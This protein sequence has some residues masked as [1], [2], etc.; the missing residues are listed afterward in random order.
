M[1]LIGCLNPTEVTHFGEKMLVPCGKCLFCQSQRAQSLVQ[2]MQLESS[3]HKYCIFGTLTYANMFLP[4]MH[5]DYD[6]RGFYFSDDDNLSVCSDGGQFFSFPYLHEESERFIKK[7]QKFYGFIP[8]LSKYDM[9]CFFKRLRIN[10]DRLIASN[11]PDDDKEKF[12]IQYVLCGEYGPTTFRPHAH[13]WLVFDSEEI[14][15]R[16]S[17]LLRASWPYGSASWRFS[18]GKRSARYI[19]QYLVCAYNL[20]ECLK[21]KEVRPFLLVSK[22]H[23]IGCAEFSK[24]TLQAYV[25]RGAAT[26]SFYDRFKGANSVVPMWRFLENRLFPKF[27]GYNYIPFG[28]RVELFGLGLV[29]KNPND[30]SDLLHAYYDTRHGSFD[31]DTFL[32]FFFPRYLNKQRYDSFS[33]N[34]YYAAKRL[35][36]NM[37]LYCVNSVVEYVRLIDLHDSNKRTYQLQQQLEFERLYISEHPN[38]IL[39]LDYSNMDD[40]VLLC[41]DVSELQSLYMQIRYSSHK[42]KSKNEYLALHPEYSILQDNINFKE[43][44]LN[45]E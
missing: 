30:L 22:K 5:Y 15:K 11:F 2:R 12:R 40:D 9:Q 41:Q 13:F 34:L 38:E 36:R 26:I 4:T 45:Y 35:R 27:S 3:N 31:L 21:R 24:E 29:A 23:P 6:S 20:P 44:F 39:Y 28:L 37:H 32:E 14:A 33:Y 10:I 42:N 7:C 17:E 19:A 25:H 1:H 8:R 18:S 43:G 16:F